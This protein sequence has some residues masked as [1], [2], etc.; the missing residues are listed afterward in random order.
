MMGL[1]SDEEGMMPKKITYS[2]DSPIFLKYPDGSEVPESLGQANYPAEG[3]DEAK[4]TRRGVQVGW[5]K[6]KQYVEIGVASFD[7]SRDQPAEGVFMTLDRNATNRL[8][9]ALQEARNSSFGKDA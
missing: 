7:P 9:R 3:F 5:M 4:W 2:D 6:N 8:I 1:T